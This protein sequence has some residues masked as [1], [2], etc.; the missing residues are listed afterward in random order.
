MNNDLDMGDIERL[1]PRCEAIARP[2]RGRCVWEDAFQDAW[3][4]AW[5][6]R[7][8]GGRVTESWFIRQFIWKLGKAWKWEHGLQHALG[9]DLGGIHYLGLG[10]GECWGAER[11]DTR[12]DAREV[13]RI[14]IR[15][16]RRAGL[17]D[18]D[19]CALWAWC[20][21]QTPQVAQQLGVS[22]DTLRKRAERAI[23]CLK[24]HLPAELGSHQR[25]A[26]CGSHS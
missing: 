24:G 1:K 20:R 16:A 26:E 9:T 10:N 6:H 7:E 13:R 14:L 19:R 12:L 21:K 4:E 11:P 8:G 3:K 18:A 15:A 23:A 22:S 5:R 25:R 2:R 17:K